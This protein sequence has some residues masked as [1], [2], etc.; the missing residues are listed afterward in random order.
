MFVISLLFL[1]LVR[2]V[3]EECINV[4]FSIC[5]IFVKYL[6]VIIFSKRFF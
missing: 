4:L 1:V 6:V 2:I 3:I 5:N